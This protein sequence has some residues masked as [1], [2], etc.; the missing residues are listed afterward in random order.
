VTA[1]RLAARCVELLDGVG[2]PIAVSAP[3]DVAAELAAR[4]AV[5]PDDAPDVP[6]SGAVYVLLGTRID[7][8]A[9]A[10]AWDTLGARLASG[11]PVVVVDHNQ[12]RTL[13]RRALGMLALAAR[14]LP[15]ER[16]RHPVAR[17]VNGHGFAIERLRLEDGERVQIVLARR[18]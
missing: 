9:R 1:A 18:R 16:A 12:P 6:I 3:P 5:A 11:A 17:E 15:P 2:G 7:E 10:A 13:A 14:G 4:V 8:P